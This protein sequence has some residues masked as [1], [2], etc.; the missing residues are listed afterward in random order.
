MTESRDI[1]RVSYRKNTEELEIICNGEIQD[2]PT[3][4]DSYSYDGNLA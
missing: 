1:R 2:G 3:L 4:E